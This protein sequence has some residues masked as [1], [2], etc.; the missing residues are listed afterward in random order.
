MKKETYVRLAIFASAIFL[1]MYLLSFGYDFTT[2]VFGADLGSALTITIVSPIIGGFVVGFTVAKRFLFGT[3]LGYACVFI[4]DFIILQLSVTP[5]HMG[6][7]STTYEGTVAWVLMS[8]PSYSLLGAVGGFLGSL[9]GKRYG[10]DV[11]KMLKV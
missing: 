11:P 5:Y 6:V 2:G 4:A 7:A 9:L 3:L 8:I 10:I 1:M